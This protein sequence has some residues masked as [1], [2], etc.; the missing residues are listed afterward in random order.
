MTGT[1]GHTKPVESC[2]PG[3]DYRERW[4]LKDYLIGQ[5]LGQRIRLFQ[6][7]M[8]ST[9]LWDMRKSKSPVCID[10]SHGW[11]TS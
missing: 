3:M 6:M 7:V 9:I 8:P 10:N 5:T 4:E 11:L 2:D 1:G